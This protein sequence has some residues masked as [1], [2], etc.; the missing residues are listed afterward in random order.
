MKYLI[1][2][3]AALGMFSCTNGKNVAQN[4]SKQR[5]IASFQ[6]LGLN[7]SQAS[8]L[9]NEVVT[10]RAAS[11]ETVPLAQ[12][13][14]EAQINLYGLKMIADSA[15]STAAKKA[16]FNEKLIAAEKEINLQTG[17]WGVR[18]TLFMGYLNNVKGYVNKNDFKG[19]ALAAQSQSKI[20]L[21]KIKAF[22]E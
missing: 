7:E 2:A 14:S 8:E 4:N 22:A 13:I 6:E 11:K 20:V 12:K 18:H 1:L 3:I 19:A 9:E 17:G 16:I 10:Y 15:Y 21:P 5:T